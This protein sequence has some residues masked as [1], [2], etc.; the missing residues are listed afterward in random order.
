MSSFGTSLEFK[1][2]S[3][4]SIIASFANETPIWSRILCLRDLAKVSQD[5][6][7]FHPSFFP[8]VSPKGLRTMHIIFRTWS[9]PTDRLELVEECIRKSRRLMVILT[10]SSGSGSEFRDKH[11]ASPQTSVLG[12]F[13]WQ[14][15]F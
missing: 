11:L 3:K 14:V 13:D 4:S 1:K 10:P 6:F 2:L 12:G 15:S 8:P 7:F 9:H 5:L